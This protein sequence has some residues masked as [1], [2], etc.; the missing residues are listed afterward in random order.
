MLYKCFVLTGFAE[1]NYGAWMPQWHLIGSDKKLPNVLKQNIICCFMVVKHTGVQAGVNDGS[2]SAVLIWTSWHQGW[3][4]GGMLRKYY[5]MSSQATSSMVWTA[6][7]GA[8]LFQTGTRGP[9]CINI[10]PYD[11]SLLNMAQLYTIKKSK[12]AASLT[13]KALKLQAV[14]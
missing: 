9:Q 8:I 2:N 5:K 6:S 11:K 12:C 13:H 4:S 3:F 10:Q 1:Q 14:K 7:A